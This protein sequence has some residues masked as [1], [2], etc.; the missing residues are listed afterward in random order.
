MQ[1]AFQNKNLVCIVL[2]EGYP[3]VLVVC[4]SFANMKLDAKCTD[5]LNE[6]LKNRPK[7]DFQ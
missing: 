2:Q 3:Y 5:K 1:T 4:T 6:A 7:C